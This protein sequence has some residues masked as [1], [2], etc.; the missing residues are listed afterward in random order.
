MVEPSSKTDLIL[1]N[2]TYNMGP[3]VPL[4]LLDFLGPLG[5]LDARGSRDPRDPRTRGGMLGSLTL[6]APESPLL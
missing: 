1:P 4:G 5:S 3:L 2:T 6:G